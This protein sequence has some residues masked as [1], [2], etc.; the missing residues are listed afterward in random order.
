MFLKEFYSG[1]ND[2]T[3]ITAEQGSLF[4]KEV[5]G[6]FNPL[7][8]IEAKRFCVPGDLLFAIVLEKYGLS[9]K[10]NFTFTGMLGHG[11]TLDFPETDAEQ[12]DIN[13][14]NNKTILQVERNGESITASKT[15]EAL[16]KDYVAFSG[17]NFP[18]VLVPLM[19]KQ[20]V[21]IN[22]TRPLVMYDSMS[23]EF[24]H[25][26]FTDPKVEMLEPVLNVNGKRGDAFLHFQ[27]KSGD[28][29]VGKGFKKIVISGMREYEE[30][31]MQAFVDNYLARKEDYLAAVVS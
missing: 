19:A 21:M 26:N 2:C 3:T 18:Y 14:S 5:A 24:D 7:H 9:K 25:L 20:Q 27:I 22:L 10:M 1:V 11:I 13:G 30:E 12:F 16:I 31:P 17:H 23:L 15:I 6:D 4:A 8:D 28:E 29:V